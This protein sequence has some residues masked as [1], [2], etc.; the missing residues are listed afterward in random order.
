M[1]TIYE[2]NMILLKFKIHIIT[3]FQVSQLLF[4]DL[5]ENSHR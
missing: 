4:S 2:E 3:K 1:N 5:R